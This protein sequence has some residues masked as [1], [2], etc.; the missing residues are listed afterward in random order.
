[1][2][3]SS[4]ALD[5]SNFEEAT[6]WA[7]DVTLVDDSTGKGLRNYRGKLVTEIPKAFLGA[8][9]KAPSRRRLR[10]FSLSTPRLLASKEASF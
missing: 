1:M 3:L 4:R 5:S 2:K 9:T 6:F 8:R 10:F 7:G